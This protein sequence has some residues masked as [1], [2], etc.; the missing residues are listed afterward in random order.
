VAIDWNSVI[1][2]SKT[3]ELRL[4]T[5][6][7]VRMPL[8]PQK[9]NGKNTVIECGSS[10]NAIWVIEKVK[11]SSELGGKMPSSENETLSHAFAIRL[12]SH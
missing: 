9:L 7:E 11:M 3:K 10:E 1:S 4:E 6:S 5:L 12:S 8:G 2:C